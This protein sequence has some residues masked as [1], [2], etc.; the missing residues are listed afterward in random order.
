MEG[1]ELALGV[2]GDF[3]AQHLSLPYE[4]ES[5]IPSFYPVRVGP[6]LC[7]VPFKCFLLS[8]Q[9]GPCSRR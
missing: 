8:P 3:S 7:S 1:L 5:L 9:W 2:K 6:E 4:G